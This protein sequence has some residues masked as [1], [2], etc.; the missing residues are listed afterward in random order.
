MGER[1]DGG[2]RTENGGR[3]TESGGLTADDDSLGRIGEADGGGEGV[4]F[5]HGDGGEP[6]GARDPRRTEAGDGGE[7]SGARDPRRTT[8]FGHGEAVAS[9]SQLVAEGHGER[10]DAERRNEGERGVRSGAGREQVVASENQPEWRRVQMERMRREWMRR[11]AANQGGVREHAPTVEKG[12]TNG[13]TAPA[14]AGTPMESQ[15]ARGP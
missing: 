9:D 14:E 5:S 1:K 13:G 15:D 3:R 4:T 11:R 7:P 6:L 2:R 12:V 10:C 8:S